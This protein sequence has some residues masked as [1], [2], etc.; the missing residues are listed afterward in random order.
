VR[1]LH[2]AD[3]H[4]GRLFHGLH[5]TRDQEHVLDQ[6]V[7]LARETRP[8]AILIAGD[9]Y[10]R[11]VPPPDAVHLLDD[12]LTRLVLELR[13][14]VVMIAG[15]HDSGERL[16]FGAR[17]LAERGLHI[18]GGVDWPPR[19]V[20]LAD[21]DGV[22]EV[23]ALPY[24]EPSALR[25][26][27]GGDATDQDGDALPAWTGAARAAR[28]PHR[29]ALLVAHAFVGGG[30]VSESERPLS[31]GGADAVAPHAFFGFSYVALGHLHR[32]QTLGRSAIRYAGSLLKY[33]F[34]E[35]QHEKS[36]SLVEIDAR[37]AC[38]VEP[39]ALSPRR[40]VRVLR[41]SMAE[42]TGT[43]PADASRQD[44]V[45]VELTDRAPIL[46]AMGRLR[47]AYPN[48]LQVDRSAFFAGLREADG[49]RPAIDH[50]RQSEVELFRSF[51]SQTAGEAPS[52]AEVAAFAAA[53]AEARRRNDA[54]ERPAL[55]PRA[56]AAHAGAAE[57]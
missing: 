20:E 41:G 25:A 48:C 33:S 21:D 4:L 40:D 54:A 36:V 8:H 37:G 26:A 22:V 29:R 10:D 11:A 27:R 15:N 31:V 43:A 12:V 1:L 19:P 2:T 16:G 28:T 39:I 6:L 51:F 30:E 47:E 55:R 49:E 32:P 3:W 57:G 50:R 52:D 46:D 45:R 14:P 35:A 5:L 42:I 23:F 34:S 53:V 38:R 24:A 18:I 9:V 56:R 44:Y 7:Q 13:L 17:L